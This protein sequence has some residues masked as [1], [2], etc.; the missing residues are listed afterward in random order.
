MANIIAVDKD[1]Y[2]GAEVAALL[3]AEIERMKAAH[4]REDLDEM[5]DLNIVGFLVHIAFQKTDDY[6]LQGLISR[7]CHDLYANQ[8]VAFLRG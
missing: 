1:Q 2:K 6:F 3:N 8:I 4:S 7:Y 5:S